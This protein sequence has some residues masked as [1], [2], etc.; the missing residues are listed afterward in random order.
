MRDWTYDGTLWWKSKTVL[1]VMLMGVFESCFL[2]VQF[3]KTVSAE[4]AEGLSLF[5]FLLLLFTSIGWLVWGALARDA[6]LL[7]TAMFNTIGALMVAVS[8]YRYGGESNQVK[9]FDARAS[10]DLGD[11]P[12]HGR[13][14][15]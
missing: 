14:G 2:Y 15:P 6:A 12:E 11:V 3:A 10:S 13:K 4:N 8:I 5:A 1:A 7:I 9:P